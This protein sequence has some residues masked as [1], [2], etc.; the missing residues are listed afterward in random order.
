M[1]DKYNEAVYDFFTEPD[2]FRTMVDVASHR[3]GLTK[4]IIQDFWSDVK[5]LI[6]VKLPKGR[7]WKVE[8]EKPYEDFWIYNKSWGGIGDDAVVSIGIDDISYGGKPNVAIL[9][10]NYNTLFNFKKIARSLRDI[11]ELDKYDDIN[12]PMWIKWQFLPFDFAEH[13][14]LVE[15][16]P[17][18]KQPALDKVVEIIFD[19]LN[20]IKDQVPLIVEE[21]RK[22]NK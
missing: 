19:M 11:P 21:N 22:R 13:K 18:T 5:T 10:D 16:L 20:A 14:N 15:I 3:D 7:G 2:N 4:K 8:F 17:A 9:V 12:D 1:K 6:E